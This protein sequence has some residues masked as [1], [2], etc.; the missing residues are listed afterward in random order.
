MGSDPIFIF[1]DV[2]GRATRE[3]A[4]SEEWLSFV[5][6]FGIVSDRIVLLES[7]TV[8][9]NLAISFDLDLEPVPPHILARVR[10][11]AAEVGIEG[12]LLE[13]PVSQSIPLVRSRVYLARALALDP[14]VLVLEHPSAQLG[15]EDAEELA[16]VVKRVCEK[17]GLTAVGLLMDEKF[18]KASGGRLLAWQPATGDVRP[19]SR[20]ARALRYF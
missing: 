13:I 5:E 14:G 15:P 16:G 9:Q 1:K 19:T 2:L 17:R 18:A 8:A 7:M 10:D 4:D 12:A 3:I 11:L 20:L 6:R